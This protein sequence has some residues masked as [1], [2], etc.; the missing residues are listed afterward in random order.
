MYRGMECRETLKLAHTKT[1]V[2]FAERLRGEILNAIEMGTFSYEKYFPESTQLAKLGIQAPR[3]DVTVG[4]LLREQIPTY[5]RSLAASTLK[6]YLR[7]INILLK[8]WD[9]TLLRALAPAALRAWLAE[10]NLKAPSIRQLLIPLRSA[11]DQAVNDDLIESSPLDRV[12]LRK[13]LSRDA[14]DSEPAADPFGPDE[15]RAILSACDGQ[16]RN[17]WQ[18]AFATGMRPSEYMALRWESVD[19]VAGTVKVER[20]RVVSVTKDETKTRAGKRLIDLRRGAHDALK[21]QEQH[22]RL[23]NELVFLD[24]ATGRGWNTSDRLHRLWAPV[25]K[26]AGVRYR[27]QYQTRHTFASTLLSTGENPMYVAKQMGHTDTTMVT[28][29][30]GRW[31]E[32]EDGVL[33]EFYFR[34]VEGK[35]RMLR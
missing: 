17:V 14:Y 8:R 26:R 9:N 35:K 29:T 11:L 2:K 33:P 30:Y 5:E 31:I 1:N 20:A 21:A 19:L 22:S 32:Q 27:T 3:L 16:L 34:M 25:V 18:F 10:L 23:A 28:R 6:S 7:N 12:K 24:P 15:I 4:D 13:V